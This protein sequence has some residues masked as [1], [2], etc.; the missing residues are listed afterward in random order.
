MRVETYPEVTRIYCRRG[1]LDTAIGA[2]EVDEA[3]AL[4]ALE[5]GLEIDGVLRSVGEESAVVPRTTP[6]EMWAAMD[7]VLPKWR[8]RKLFVMPTCGPLRDVGRRGP[9]RRPR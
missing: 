9:T 6:A 1:I 7:R 2:I 5:L 4:L 8:Q 3:L